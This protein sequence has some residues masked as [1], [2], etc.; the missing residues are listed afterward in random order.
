MGA[1]TYYV[2]SGVT[3]IV[4]TD[5]GLFELKKDLSRIPYTDMEE[6][7]NE[8]FTCTKDCAEKTAKEFGRE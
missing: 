5:D 2:A 6:F 7:R 4:G 3:A 8:A 1:E